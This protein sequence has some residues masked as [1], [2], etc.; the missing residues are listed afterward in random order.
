MKNKPLFYATILVIILALIVTVIWFM[1]RPKPTEN[2]PN[3]P[4]NP[5]SSS[6]IERTLQVAGVTWRYTVDPTFESKYKIK[7][8]TGTNEATLHIGGNA[9]NY[10]NGEVYQ[11]NNDVFY[12]NEVVREI[13]GKKYAMGPPMQTMMACDG[14]RANAD[15]ELQA[16]IKEIFQSMK[17]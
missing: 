17:L 7:V 16:E 2:Q 6:R 8:E 5:G 15:Q 14:D 11:K 3:P 10:M 1:Y 9:C 4:S 12:E 13:G